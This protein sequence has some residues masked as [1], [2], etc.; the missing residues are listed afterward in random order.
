MNPSRKAAE[1]ISAIGPALALLLA[2]G[3][4]RDARRNRARRY[5]LAVSYAIAERIE[6]FH[7]EQSTH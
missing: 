6:S 3:H 5:W 7:V 2:E 1:L 4:A